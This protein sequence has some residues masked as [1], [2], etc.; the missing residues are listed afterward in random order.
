MS[1]PL[2]AT[3]RSAKTDFEVV[4][5]WPLI[6]TVICLALLFLGVPLVY[7]IWF[8]EPKPE[9]IAEAKR[10]PEEPV[11]WE[12]PKLP[13]PPPIESPRR[14][15]EPERVVTS[16]VR[17]EPVAAVERLPVAPAEARPVDSARASAPIARTESTGVYTEDAPNR[18]RRLDEAQL[19]LYLQGEVHELDLMEGSS[20][21][22]FEAGK[23]S[24]SAAAGVGA[25][26]KLIGQ[27]TDLQGLE[28]QKGAAC[29]IEGEQARKLAQLSRLVRSIQGQPAGRGVRSRSAAPENRAAQFKALFTINHEKDGDAQRREVARTLHLRSPSELGD[30]AAPILL[31]ML[32]VEEPEIRKE[33]IAWLGSTRGPKS[34]AALVQRALFDPVPD[35]REAAVAVLKGRAPAEYRQLLVDALRHPWPPAADHAAQALAALGDRAILGGLVELL[36]QP[37]PRAPRRQPDGKWVVTELVRVNH[38]RNCMLC[39]AASA[40]REDPIRGL[41]PKTHEPLPVE[42]YESARGDF[43]RADITYVRQDFSALHPVDDP[44]PWPTVQ[45]FDYLRRTREASPWEIFSHFAKGTARS[46][47][48]REA[49][50]FALRELTGTDAGTSAE[51]WRPWL[52]KT[53]AH[54]SQASMSKSGLEWRARP[55]FPLE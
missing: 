22:L 41:I 34:S 18:P 19:L 17:V 31:Q 29:Q 8:S 5:N 52:R 7:S 39:H 50:L 16:P 47:P 37:D 20:L 11:I 23:K 3:G 6:V 32:Q 21:E 27:R 46:Y 49:V 25:L 54:N 9:P 53:P 48:Q 38:L 24:A 15:P 33:F 13:A 40:S 55:N 51:A 4:T 45:R 42:Y 26:E 12:R 44:T 14:Q 43:V 28:L 35:L 10:L 1:K 36:D 30:L 2:P